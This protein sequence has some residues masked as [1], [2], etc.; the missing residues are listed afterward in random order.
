MKQKILIIDD[1]ESLRY[2]FAA[3]LTDEGYE[4]ASAETFDAGITHLAE[5]SVDLIFADILLGDKTGIDLLREI[6]TRNLTCPVVM[7]T[8]SPNFETASEALRLG[9]FD[10]LAK[11]VTQKALLHTAALA[12]KQ[13]AL[14]D[15]NERIRTNLEAVFRSV[16]DGIITVDS[17]ML[18]IEMNNAAQAICGYSRNSAQGQPIA[19]LPTGCM[20]KCLEALTKTIQEKKTVELFRIDCRHKDRPGQVVNVAT[21]P[22]IGPHHEFS[23]AVMV[24][25][26]E[27]RIADLE[28]DM[29]QRKQFHG[30]IGKSEQM[31]NIYS[32]VEQV[33][34]FPTTVLIRGESGTGK[35]LVAEALHYRGTRSAKSLIRVNCASLPENLLESEL[36]GHVKGA[37]TGAISDR[38]GRFELADKGTI[39]L[40]EIGDMPLSVQVRLLRVLQERE[41]ERVGS[42]APIKVDVRVIAATNNNLLEKIQKGEFREDLYYRLKVVEMAIPPLRQRKEDIPLLTAHFI[43]RFSRKFSKD[44]RDVSAAVMDLF[45]HHNWPGNIRELE[46]VLEH[47][48]ILCR[49]GIITAE[50]LPKDFIGQGRNIES[51]PDQAGE[52]EKIIQALRKA[53]GNKAKAAR[54]L[55]ISRR[56]M[57][58]KIEDLQIPDTEP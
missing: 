26:D 40:D 17:G 50:C 41:F 11:P 16:R 27:T 36:F 54:L 46:H 18:V 29:G 56:T 22:L 52:K 45:M 37:F 14:L 44:I 8:G 7:V 25:S 57:Y 19:S 35:E 9:A 34:D 12:L 30:M 5:E 49:D 13:K 21:S 23:G 24:L 32:L 53:G 55:G 51:S 15:E 42:A 20:K 28:S 43:R 6:R 4:V 31:Q 58:R 47:A 38:A 39:F 2:T 1:E 33:A 48:C 3:F 10:Y